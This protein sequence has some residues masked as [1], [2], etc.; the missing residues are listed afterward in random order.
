MK[1]NYLLICFLA[2]LPIVANAEP[3]EIDG[4]CYYL[5]A[6]NH[7]ARVNLKW[8]NN[9]ICIY[10]GNLVDT[11]NIE[12]EGISYDVTAISEFAFQGATGPDISNSPK[13]YSY[14]EEIRF[15]DVQV[16]LRLP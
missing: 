12:H 5:N 14:P 11:F 8:D 2:L 1:K 16:S 3:V 7:S 6:S 15:R 9:N 10:E 13:R 4:I